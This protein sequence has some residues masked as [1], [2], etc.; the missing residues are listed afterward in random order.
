MINPRRISMLLPIALLTACGKP[1]EPLP[2]PKH[3]NRIV[4]MAPSLTECLFAIGAG[5]RVVGDTT[6]CTYP[7]EAAELPK[8]GG[9]TDANYEKLYTLKPDMVVL[10][11]EHV[12]A[13][14]RLRALGIPCARLDTSTMP[15][16]LN[17]L[18]TLGNL[19]DEQ[20]KS[21]A[22]VAEIQERMSEIR[23]RTAHAPQRRVLIS[24]G[25]NMGTGTLSDIYVVGRNTLYHEMLE[26]IGAENVYTGS[27]EYAH[28]SQEG[29]MR[30]APDVVIDLIPDLGTSV[31]MTV[32]EVRAQWNALE[33]IPAVKSGQ[34]YVCD[35]DYVCV[36]GPRFILVFEDIARAVYP[37]CFE[38]KP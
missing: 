11:D 13:V 30:L 12:A 31:Q 4:S 35:D 37:E 3:V 19:L 8:I 28:M 10:L 34:V 36:P 18:Q 5:D 20:E 15:S 21:Q 22:I 33:N 25:R 27:L 38:E 32:E 16:I 29:I 14:E 6:F 2:M 23:K 1:A 26:T 24:I 17:T 7:P 9:Y